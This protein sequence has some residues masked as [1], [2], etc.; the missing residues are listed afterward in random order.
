MNVHCI[1]TSIDAKGTNPS[2]SPQG[3]LWD[4]IY[5][6]SPRNFCASLAE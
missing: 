1:V 6:F 5:A 4:Q 3:L 2:D